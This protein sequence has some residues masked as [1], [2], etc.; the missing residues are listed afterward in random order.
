MELFFCHLSG[1]ERELVAEAEGD[2]G[3][4]LPEEGLEFQE[5]ESL[6]TTVDAISLVGELKSLTLSEFIA[7]AEKRCH[8]FRPCPPLLSDDYAVAEIG[9]VW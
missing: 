2:D 4:V 6:L 3:G 8:P 7:S 1:L 9:S 5:V